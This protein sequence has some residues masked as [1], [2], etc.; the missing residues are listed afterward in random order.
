M[1]AVLR[2]LSEPHRRSILRLV[3]QHEMNASQIAANF[4]ITRPAVSQ[5]LGVLKE[6]K[7]I[8][9]R[10][11]GTKRFY[12]ASP[13]GLIELRAY[14]ESFWDTSLEQLKTAAQSEQKRTR[15][16]RKQPT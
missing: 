8:S 2:A 15:R 5:H 14:L 1:E 3:V 12:R 6:A 11:E 9:E 10:R 7:L 4:Q 16:E 13:E